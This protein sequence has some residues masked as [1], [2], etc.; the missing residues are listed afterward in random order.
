M[1]LRIDNQIFEIDEKTLFDWIRL[2]RITADAFVLSETLTNGQWRQLH[3]LNL[4]IDEEPTEVLFT[5][6]HALEEEFAKE[7]KFLTYQR[8]R[9]IITLT[10]I[11]V[12][13][14]AFILLDQ[15]SGRSQDAQTL[16]RFGAYSYDLIFESGEYWRLITNTFLHI[17]V[18]HLFLNM[19]LLLIA[20]RLIE[21]LYGKW[22]FLIIYLVSAIGGSVMSLFFVQ[23]AIGAGA[24]GA[25]F[26]L[27]GT[28]VVLG[29]RYKDQ[30]P[31][32]QG[33]IFGFRL[34]PFI[35]ID[36]AL[37]FSIPYINNTIFIPYF[38]FPLPQINNAAHIG[39]LIFGCLAALVLPPVIHTNREHERKIIQW[40][41]VGFAS[42]VVFSGVMATSYFSTDRTVAV[43]T[44]NLST[45][46]EHYERLLRQRGYV[47]EDYQAL[48]F[49]YLKAMQENPKEVAW[50]RKLKALYERAL[51]EDPERPTWNE[52][53][54]WLYQ[55]TAFDQPDEQE[56]VEDYIKLYEKVIRR[57]GYHQLPYK[58]TEYFYMRAKKLTPH[59]KSPWERKLEKLYQEAITGEP[60]HATWH[61]NLAWLYVE[62]KRKTQKAVEWAQQ[63]VKLNPKSTMFLDTLG[64]SYLRHG[65]YGQAL[66]AFELVFLTSTDSLFS[67]ESKFQVDLDNGNFSEDL[68]Q[69]FE[70]HGL[71]LSQNVKVS[72]SGKSGKWLIAIAARNRQGVLIIR[73]GEG[74][75]NVYHSDSN[76]D[77]QAKDSSWE[78][79]SVLIQLDIAS[80]ESEKFTREFLNFYNRMSRQLEGQLEALAKLEGA[81]ELFQAHQKG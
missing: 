49:L 40:I 18:V 80:S 81:F 60:E 64:W 54:R 14:A 11:V 13:I 41:G 47:P 26:G 2:G 7:R 35:G 66:R 25:I 39:G 71:T 36:I 28:I 75:L 27:M 37:G 79:L 59:D 22:R 12:N 5:Q 23:I 38:N 69:A 8:A 45:Q 76:V 50:V 32:R 62:Q 29:L 73:K 21:G 51:L 52:H 48:E 78:G 9:P 34:V 33:R 68:R 19:A 15:M 58:N 46:I 30:I 61:N 17:G 72:I 3:E 77:L 24:S 67:I 56:E 43:A 55:E 42:L 57:R 63:A 74:R 20:G 10:L 4:G 44:T 53:L 31:R 65:Q 70:N 16:I 6:L 1:K